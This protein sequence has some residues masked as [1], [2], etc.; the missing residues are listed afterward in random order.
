MARRR[1]KSP[2]CL[3]TLFMWPFE[4][5]ISLMIWIFKLLLYLMWYSIL[6][7]FYIVWYVLVGMFNITVSIIF[8]KKTGF[9]A[10]CNSGEEY[11]IAC[12]QILKQYGFTHIETTKRSGDHGIDILAK[13]NGKKYA[14]QCKYY[15]STVGNHAVQEAYSGCSYYGYDIPVVL[16]NSTFTSNAQDEARRLGVHLWAQNRIPFFK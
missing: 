5:T 16:T 11:E 9:N 1:K 7:C 10:P 6:F 13:R 3:Y 8:H 12:C 4:L 2:G 14:I 15:S